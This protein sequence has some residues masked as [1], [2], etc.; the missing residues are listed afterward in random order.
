MAEDI[1]NL[2]YFSTMCALI[3]KILIQTE[4][5]EI[6]NHCFPTIK[7]IKWCYRHGRRA[8]DHVVVLLHILG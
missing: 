6:N 8:D 1:F 2:K 7:V 3:Y 4:S 5:N